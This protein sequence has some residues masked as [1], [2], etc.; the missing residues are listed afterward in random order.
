MTLEQ[1]FKYTSLEKSFVIGYYGGTNFGDELLLETI[2]NLLSKSGVK[3]ASL[4]YSNSNIFSNYH[5]NLG[6]RVIPASIKNILTELI[7][8]SSIIIGGGG[9]WGLDFNKNIALLSILLF[10]TRHI[11]RKKVYLLGVGSYSSA[12]LLGKY[13]SIIAALSANIIFARDIES[14]NNFKKFNKNTYLNPD[15]AFLLP[16]LDLTG[17]ANENN[18]LSK[19]RDLKNETLIISVR[20]FSKRHT[21]KKITEF[22]NLIEK[23]I[24]DSKKDIILLLLT[25][26]EFD[27][28]NYAFCKKLQAKYTNVIDVIDNTYN[29]ISLYLFLKQ[30]QSKLRMIAPQFH[31]QIIA[32][33]TDVPF[34]PLAYDNK[35]TELHKELGIERS[36]LFSEIRF[37]DVKDFLNT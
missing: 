26:K 22:N 24:K 8:S 4:Y 34:F 13:S 35:V 36:Y 7:K 25:S 6:F 3:E 31:M 19:V 1:F 17:Y 29:P 12:P 10:I 5:H 30:H 37:E 11:L 33:L 23:I 2:Q 15:I 21:D 16:K 18:S 27:P 20:H 32:H 9:L 14:F 28:N